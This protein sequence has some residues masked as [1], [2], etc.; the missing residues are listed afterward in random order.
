[1]FGKGF[2]ISSRENFT[3][4]FFCGYNLLDPCH[5]SMA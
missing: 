2:Y 1:M 3:N 4:K 5:S